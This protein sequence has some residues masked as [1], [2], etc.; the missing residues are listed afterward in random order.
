MHSNAKYIRDQ[1]AQKLIGNTEIAYRHYRGGTNFRYLSVVTASESEDD[2][3]VIAVASP[4]ALDCLAERATGSCDNSVESYYY[5]FETNKCQ[6]F[7]YS[8]C[9]GNSN[10]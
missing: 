4:D 1:L 7:L 10:R 8:G 9:G 6:F 2:F 5:D 3:I